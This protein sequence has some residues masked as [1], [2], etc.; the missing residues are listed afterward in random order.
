MMQK[1][2]Y[3]CWALA[4][5]LSAGLID[6]AQAD[7]YKYVDKDGVV[8]FTNTPTQGHYKFFRKESSPRKESSTPK[9]SV[10]SHQVTDMIRRHAAQ[11]RLEEALVSAV[12]KA[13]SNFNPQAVSHK[14][15]I[16]MMQLIPAT[17]RLMEV[18][19]PLNPEENIRGG[20]RYLRL[21]LDE[22]DGNLELALAAYN[23]G[24]NAVKRYGGIPPYAETRTYV[25]RVKKYMEQFQRSKDTVL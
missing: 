12:I 4:L 9:G 18:R 14:G 16:G 20:S 8:H 17:A 6:A 5:L 11:Y 22:F 19:D 3:G 23:A 15:A 2:F 7:I 13:E 25:E 1:I 10:A 21:M 24:P